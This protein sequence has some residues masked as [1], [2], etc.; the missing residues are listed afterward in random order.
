MATRTTSYSP[1]EVRDDFVPKE[2][3]YD[4]DFA[5][6]EAERLWPFVWQVAAREEEIPNVGD[7]VVY[8]IL[9]DSIVVVR[10]APDRIE[11]HHNVCPH[12]GRRLVEGVGNVGKFHCAFHGWQFALTG[13]N[14]KVV[15]KFDWADCLKDEDIALSS[16]QCDTW[17]G[18]VF[19]NMD[20][21]AGPLRDF[22]EPLPE[23]LDKFE[24][25]RL[26]FR[27]YK[28]TVME[29]NWKTVLGF[30]NEF[31]HVQQAHPQLLEF[32]ND[33]S[34]SIELGRHA[35]T[36]YDHKGAVPIARSPRL[37]QAPEPSMLEHVQNLGEQYR[38]DLEVMLSER[39]WGVIQTLQEHV[40]TETPPMEVLAKWGELQLK[41]AAEEGIEWPSQLTPEYIERSGL[42]WHAFPNTIFLHG[43]VDSVL[44]YR[45]RPYGDDPEKCIFDVWALELF[46]EGKAPPLVRQHYTDWED[47]NFPLIYAQDFVN[48]PEVQKGFHS[49]GFKGERTNPVQERAISNFHRVLRQFLADPHDQPPVTKAR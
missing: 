46:G 15:D 1:D 34:G 31:Y 48:I 40:S 16:I 23:Y 4:K 33:Y 13:E 29:S 42:A 8:D 19:I 30:F 6:L 44:W 28:S 49:R 5:A 45:L 12:R 20:P 47:A 10:T 11:A 38:R 32:T 18:F 39:N 24:F 22:L 35:Q 14:V 17:G 9:K 7:Y 2:V 37:P 41:A 25:E 27:W 43:L 36:F 26:R 3:Y 21:K